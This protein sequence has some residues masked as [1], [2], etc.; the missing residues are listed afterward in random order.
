MRDTRALVA[1]IEAINA[2]SDAWI[3]EDPENRVAGQIVTLPD[4]WADYDV[5]TPEE[6]DRYLLE[7]DYVEGYKELYGIRA[8]VSLAYMTDEMLTQATDSIYEQLEANIEDQ[9]EYMAEDDA[10]ADN[11]DDWWMAETIASEDDELEAAGTEWDDIAEDFD[12]VTVVKQ[13]FH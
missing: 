10:A 7:Q 6:F 3:A 2:K 11:L 1:H 8:R 13:V 4:H 9:R 12:D 5:Y